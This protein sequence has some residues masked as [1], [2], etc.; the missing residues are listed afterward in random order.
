MVREITCSGLATYTEL[1]T[2]LGLED[3]M[4]LLEIHHVNEY[5]KQVMKE[6]SQ[7]Q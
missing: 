2:T 1:T 4:N 6:L 3:A 7:Q 5:N